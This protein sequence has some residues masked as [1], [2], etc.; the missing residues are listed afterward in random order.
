MEVP[1]KLIAF[2][3]SGREHGQSHRMVLLW[4]RTIY[5]L[6]ICAECMKDVDVVYCDGRR[7]HGVRDRECN[8]SSLGQQVTTTGMQ[9]ERCPAREVIIHGKHHRILRGLDAVEFLHTLRYLPNL[10]QQLLALF[11]H[12]THR[13][14][15]HCKTCVYGTEPQYTI[16]CSDGDNSIFKS[17]CKYVDN[18]ASQANKCM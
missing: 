5:Q 6:F 3:D 8:R 15:R 4:K 13:D 11:G 7:T 10:P 1:V 12:S 2:R 9:F 18:F 17:I 14:D 16:S